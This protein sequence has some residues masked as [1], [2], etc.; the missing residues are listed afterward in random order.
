MTKAFINIRKLIGIDLD[1]RYISEWVTT[2]KLNT[3]NLFEK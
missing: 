1:W 3:F 2:L